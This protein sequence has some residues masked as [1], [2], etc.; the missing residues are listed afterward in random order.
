VKIR[1]IGTLE[2]K[3]R[4]SEILAEVESGKHFYI[5]RHGRTIAELSPFKS[6]KIQPKFGCGKGIFGYV[7]P[8]FDAPL[9]D[10]KEYSE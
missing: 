9:E 2:A 7:A 3:T 10:F 5:T 8:D 6:K 1:E 4:L